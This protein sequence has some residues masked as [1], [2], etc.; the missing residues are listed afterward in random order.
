MAK[1]KESKTVL[2]RVD[3]SDHTLARKMLPSFGARGMR[4]LFH[5]LVLNYWTLNSFILPEKTKEK[6][7]LIINE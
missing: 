7:E 2:I 6:K 1:E 4:G 3:R 5:T